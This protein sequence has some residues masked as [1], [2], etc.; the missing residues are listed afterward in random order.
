[1]KQKW[2]R[3]MLLLSLALVVLAQGALAAEGK[4]AAKQEA[5]YRQVTGEVVSIGQDGI[6]I[7][8]RTKGTMKLAVTKTTDMI[9]TAVK[10]GDKATVNYRADQSGNTATRITGKTA[11]AKAAGKATA[12]ASASPAAR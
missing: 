10:A 6:V 1:M 5:T 4:K 8:S 2:M 12:A 3:T 9:G 7:K 11:S